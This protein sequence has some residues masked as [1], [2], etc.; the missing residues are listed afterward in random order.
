VR[1]QLSEPGGEEGVEDAAG[2]CCEME[3][4]AVDIERLW[5]LWMRWEGQKRTK[6]RMGWQQPLPNLHGHH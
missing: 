1:R 3:D 5:G 6:E 2:R 4:Y